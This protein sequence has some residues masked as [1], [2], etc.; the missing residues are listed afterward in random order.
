MSPNNSAIS[1]WDFVKA[2]WLATGDVQRQMVWEAKMVNK[3]EAGAL[4]HVAYNIR[5]YITDDLKLWELL[6]TKLEGEKAEAIRAMVD[7]VRNSL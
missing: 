4:G 7:F 2:E 3:Q 5:R 1:G 6:G